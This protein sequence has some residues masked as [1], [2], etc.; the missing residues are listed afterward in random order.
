MAY[1]VNFAEFIEL[2][3]RLTVDIHPR[4]GVVTMGDGVP[5]PLQR[6]QAVLWTVTCDDG[7]IER[8]D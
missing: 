3:G 6:R 2:I 4:R 7:G 5:K 8:A 1:H